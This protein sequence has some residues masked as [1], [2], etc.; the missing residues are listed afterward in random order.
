MS[1]SGY[2]LHGAVWWDPH[3]DRAAGSPLGEVG[4]QRTHSITESDHLGVPPGVEGSK[5]GRHRG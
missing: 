3:L 1:R 2:A 5:D 4:Q